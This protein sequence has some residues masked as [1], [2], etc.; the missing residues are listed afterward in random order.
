MYLTCVYCLVF[1]CRRSQGRGNRRAAGAA[2]RRDVLSG[3]AAADWTPASGGSQWNPRGTDQHR[4]QPIGQRRGLGRS[5]PLLWQRQE[6]PG[7]E[8]EVGS[9]NLLEHARN[10]CCLSIVDTFHFFLAV[11]L[12][13]CRHHCG[14]PVRKLRLDS[15]RSSSWRKSK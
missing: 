9:W 11:I 12:L 1:S 10:C 2:P 4:R 14:S 5:G 13:T 15:R 7:Q 6:R 8:E 3:N